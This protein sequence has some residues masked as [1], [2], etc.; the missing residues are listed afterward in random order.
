MIH[1]HKKHQGIFHYPAIYPIKYALP[2]DG[3]FEGFLEYEGD[4]VVSGRLRF[5]SH[6][7]V[8]YT[9][10]TLPPTSRV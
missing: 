7:P 9:H 8:S 5:G 4:G 10:L 6:T 3:L 1:E 2:R